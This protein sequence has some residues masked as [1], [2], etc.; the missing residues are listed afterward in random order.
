[1]EGSGGGALRC[2]PGGLKEGLKR[3]ARADDR[4][5]GTTQT[6]RERSRNISRSL[7]GHDPLKGFHRLPRTATGALEA[8]TRKGR[9]RQAG[10]G[11]M[12]L[13]QQRDARMHFSEYIPGWSIPKRKTKIGLTQAGGQRTMALSHTRLLG[14]REPHARCRRRPLRRE[15]LATLAL[16]KLHR[17]P[18]DVPGS[19]ASLPRGE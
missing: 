16:R 1:M 8:Q 15:G 7:Q 4:L 13:R 12:P 5:M 19:L 11:P 3:V 18:A 2:W 6:V 14:A 10:D 9:E 17:K